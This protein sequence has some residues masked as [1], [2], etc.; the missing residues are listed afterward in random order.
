M[1]TVETLRLVVAT[2]HAVRL[3]GR[4]GTTVLDAVLAVRQT[5]Q[6]ALVGRSDSPDAHTL[7]AVVDVLHGTS[8][9]PV[10]LFGGRLRG[11]AA[12]QVLLAT[13]LAV[14]EVAAVGQGHGRRHP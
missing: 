13:A 5:G 7:S 11:Y 4:R 8:M 3:V 6:A 14:A 12:V 1:S 2:G 9:V 10:A